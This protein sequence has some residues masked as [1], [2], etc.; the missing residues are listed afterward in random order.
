M[1]KKK[2]ENII[3]LATGNQKLC[4]P[5][6]EDYLCMPDVLVGNVI[7]LTFTYTKQYE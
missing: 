5:L 7:N 6:Y 1:Q 2:Y 4:V 3:V